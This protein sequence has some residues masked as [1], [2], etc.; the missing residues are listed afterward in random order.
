M[1]EI[2]E[3]RDLA[4]PKE[5][6]ELA[7]LYLANIK[8]EF[9]T[10][11][12][13]EHTYR[14]ALKGLIEALGRDVVAI[15]EPKRETCGAPD[16]VIRRDNLS[17]GY[18]ETKIIGKSLD[19]VENS[20]QIKRYRESLHNLI[21][22]DYLEFRW[23]IYDERRE[24]AHIGHIGKSGK[25]IL[26]Q[27]GCTKVISLFDSYLSQKIE[28][29]TTPIDLANQLAR[30]AKII[31]NIVLNSFEHNM[32]SNELMDLRESIARVLI[33]EIGQ[34]ER[35]SEFADMYAQTIVY[36][37]FAARCNHDG[38]APFLRSNAASE[39]PKTNPFLRKLFASITGLGMEDEPHAPFIDDLVQIL[40]S[41]D[42]DA[43]LSN[44]GKRSKQEDP[45]I[46]FYETFLKAYDPSLRELRGVYYTP[47]PIV[48]YIVRSVDLVLK[49]HFEISGG[50]LDTLSESKYN[51][52]KYFTDHRGMPEDRQLPRTVEITCPKVLILDPACGTGTF[53]YNIIDYIRNSYM[54]TMGAGYWSL[55]VREKLLK[56]IFGFELLMASYAVAHFK[57]G[58]QLSGRDLPVD[59]QDFWRYDFASNERLGI[60]LTNTL[61]E[62]ENIWSTL[63]SRTLTEEANE[64]S[65]VKKDMPIMVVL[66][67]PPYSGHSANSSWEIVKGKRKLNFIGQLLKDYYYVDG[68][69]LGEK[70]SK[71]LQDDYVKFIRWGQWRVEQTGVGVLAFITN[72]GYLDNPT[73]RGMRQQLMNTFNDIYI[74]NLHGNLKKREC[75]P[76]AQIDENVFDIQVGVC[77]GIFIK[78]NKDAGTTKIN[79]ADLWGLREEK[80]RKLMVEDIKTTLWNQIEP[81]TPDYLFIP[82]NVD[83]KTEYEGMFKITDIMPSNVMG[84]QTHRDHFVIAF[85]SNE[86]IERA[87]QLID[88]CISNDSLKEKYHL[89]DNRDWQLDVA[90]KK[91][92]ADT[93][94]ETRILECLYRPFDLRPCYFDDAVMDYPR[95]ELEQNMLQ[96]NKAIGLGRQGMAVGP[97]EWDVLCVSNCPIDANVFRR[98]GVNIFYLYKYQQIED[99]TQQK[100]LSN[101]RTWPLGK[102]G[103]IPNINPKFVTHLERQ[104]SMKFILDFENESENSFGPEDVF[105]YIYALL[106]SP[107]FRKRYAEFLK[108]DFPRIPLT[109]DITIFRKL[110]TLGKELVSLHL[111]EPSKLEESRFLTH[112]PVPGNNIVAKGYPE[113]VILEKGMGRVYIYT[114]QYL[115]NVPENVW[116]FHVGGYLVCEKWLKDRRGRQ[117]SYDDITKYRRIIATLIETIHL[118]EEID[119]AIPEWPVK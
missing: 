30:I 114:S 60:F 64:A 46:H 27:K 72:H 76:D 111:L 73:F 113:F 89:N 109:S 23:Y 52:E 83:L 65:V 15:N 18:I 107:T 62:A 37:L 36:G 10:G 98:G 48:S 56:R 80:Y 70:N 38:P 110:C 75:T 14:A 77:I 93:N 7:K 102:C 85:E 31:R 117:L 108:L 8:R 105:H 19:E 87:K 61:Q 2:P 40:N 26:D 9:E 118:M 49:N 101:A 57:L 67:N 94:W 22:T 97:N 99:L 45:V 86:I 88:P 50:F 21:L 33:P 84:F 59:Q 13:T 81:I 25:I 42:M 5:N 69:P 1:I 28:K 100:Q 91:I 3:E 55:F 71:W 90:R 41:T 43:V 39:I 58:M 17:V 12:A 44:F 66:G 103:R 82:Q 20:D 95:R 6:I 92:Q 35:I 112:Y 79:Y 78:K 32:V 53:L 47:E 74:L 115:E 54:E 63:F 51:R 96:P 24:V 16:F 104:L 29:I 4:A 119:K 116:N 68:K 34:P 11:R 106:C